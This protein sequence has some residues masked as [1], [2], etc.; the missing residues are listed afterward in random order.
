MIKRKNKIIVEPEN[1][2]ESLSDEEESY[3][4][5]KGNNMNSTS[6]IIIRLLLKN[7]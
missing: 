6:S 4:T 1:E 5:Q 2:D 7:V 3:N